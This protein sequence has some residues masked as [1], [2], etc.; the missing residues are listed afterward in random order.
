M[1]NSEYTA[2]PWQRLENI[3]RHL[4]IIQQHHRRIHECKQCLS[5]ILC[6]HNL[7]IPHDCSV[8]DVKLG[9]TVVLKPIYLLNIYLW[10]PSSLDCSS[11]LTLMQHLNSLIKVFYCCSFFNTVFFIAVPF[12][13]IVHLLR[14]PDNCPFYVKNFFSLCVS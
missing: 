8:F 12:F 9:I 5:D 6:V 1:L 2:Y 4:E 13:G 7:G 14:F 11:S 3:G 10:F